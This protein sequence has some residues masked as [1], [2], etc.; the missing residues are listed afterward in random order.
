MRCRE[1]HGTLRGPGG[2][3]R[4]ERSGGLDY[5]VGGNDE[6]AAHPALLMSGTVEGGYLRKDLVDVEQSRGGHLDFDPGCTSTTMRGPTS[7]RR[8]A[9]RHRRR[10]LCRPHGSNTD[11]VQRVG[12]LADCNEKEGSLLFRLSTAC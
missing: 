2:E 8:S 7:G 12:I 4:L 11:G 3:A 1:G 6:V 9:T 5:L 10:S